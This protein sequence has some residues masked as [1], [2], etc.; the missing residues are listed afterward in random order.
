MIGK[1]IYNLSSCTVSVDYVSLRLLFSCLCNSH[2]F[3]LFPLRNTIRNHDRERV[4]TPGMDLLYR[5][6]HCHCNPSQTGNRNRETLCTWP[7]QRVK[8]FYIEHQCFAVTV[9]SSTFTSTCT[10]ED[11]CFNCSIVIICRILLS[12]GLRK[13][14]LERFLLNR[15]DI[16][17]IF[18]NGTGTI[19]QKYIFRGFSASRC[20]VIILSLL[21]WNSLLFGRSV[22]L[23]KQPYFAS[24]TLFRRLASLSRKYLDITLTIWPITAARAFQTVSSSLLKEMLSAFKNGPHSFRNLLMMTFLTFCDIIKTILSFRQQIQML[25]SDVSDIIARLKLVT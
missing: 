8:T 22:R 11:F 20:G 13:T 9:F 3:S 24:K 1:I 4:V 19:I 5:L 10:T 15:F 6:R 18:A 17:S 14:L 21:F 2:V 12:I 7:G 16:D 23:G 25:G